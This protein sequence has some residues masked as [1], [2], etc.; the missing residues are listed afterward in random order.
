MSEEIPDQGFTDGS[1]EAESCKQEEA[2]NVWPPPA[3][4]KQVF[5]VAYIQKIEV[6]H[7]QRHRSSSTEFS[8]T[9]RRNFL[10]V[11]RQA[12]GYGVTLNSGDRKCRFFSE[13]ATPKPH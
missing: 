2:L 10:L 4:K 3:D 13:H 12:A 5:S 11:G 8:E 7:L 6:M 9:Q 1:F